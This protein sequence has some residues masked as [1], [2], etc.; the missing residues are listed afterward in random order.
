V[1]RFKVEQ[2]EQEHG[3]NSFPEFRSLT[4][5]EAGH[6][7]AVLKR[8]LGLLDELTAQEVLHTIDQ[9][10]VDV[11]GV[12]TTEDAF[13]LRLVLGRLGFSAERVFINWY[14]FDRIDEFSIEDFCNSF[15]EFFYPSADD[16][17]ILDLDLAWLV[18]IRHCG[19]V[20]ALGLS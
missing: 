3:A 6:V 11:E 14:R 16:L 17:E 15:S 18:S 5:E 7:L 12:D 13:D 9:R 2:F 20:R 8:R 19:A 1:E 10:S 4:N